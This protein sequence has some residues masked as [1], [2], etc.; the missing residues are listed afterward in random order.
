MGGFAQFRVLTINGDS[1]SILNFG[2]LSFD[3]HGIP[4]FITRQKSRQIVDRLFTELLYYN[5]GISK[6]TTFH[7]F[8]GFRQSF[9]MF[10][11]LRAIPSICIRGPWLVPIENLTFQRTCIHVFKYNITYFLCAPWCSLQ[12]V[13]TLFPCGKK[14]EV[15]SDLLPQLL[16]LHL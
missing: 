16:A 3:D 9:K 5:L 2:T 13:P 14:A 15:G 6:V 8:Q 4:Y 10:S 7:Q 1:S 11:P 12:D